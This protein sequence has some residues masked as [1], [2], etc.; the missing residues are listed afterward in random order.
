LTLRRIVYLI[1]VFSLAACSLTLP[2]PYPPN[3]QPAAIQAATTPPGT[4]ITPPAALPTRT[5]DA[6]TPVQNTPAPDARLPVNAIPLTSETEAVEVSPTPE[7]TLPAIGADN[8][9]SLRPATIYPLFRRGLLHRAIWSPDGANLV[10]ETSLGLQVLSAQNLEKRFSLPDTRPLYFIDSGELLVRN[11]RSLSLLDLVEGG[12][13]P[14]EVPLPEESSGE[15]EAYALSPDGKTW[16]LSADGVSL[17]VTDLLNAR[18]ET[19]TLKTQT[20]IPFRVL[21]LSFAP[22]GQRLFA[23]LARTDGETE[24]AVV[25]TAAWQQIYT[26]YNVDSSPLF[27]ADA[28]RMLFESGEIL[29]VAFTGDGMLWNNMALRIEKKI[30]DSQ[31][32]I[33]TAKAYAFFNG[34]REVGVLYNDQLTDR[35][36]PDNRWF[37]STLMIFDTDTTKVTRYVNGLPA[38]ITG[39]SFAPDGERFLTTSEDGVLRVFDTSSEKQLLS[40]E[41]YDVDF[42]PQVRADGR[43]VAYSLLESVSLTDPATGHEL[44]QLGSYPEATHLEA[45]FAGMDTLAIF[46]ETPWRKF[47]DTYDIPSG[48]FLFRYSDLGSCTFNR[49]G[50]IM[51]CF[52][53]VL[54]FFDMPTGRALLDNI[55]QGSGF[56]YSISDSGARVAYCTIGSEFVYLYE[57]RLGS[58]PK[59]IITGKRGVCGKLV[60]SPDES[61]LISSSGFVWSVK[62]GKLLKTFDGLTGGGPAA[63]SPDGSLLLVYPQIANLLNGEVE[64]ELQS[65][66]GVQ[67]AYFLRDGQHLLLQTNRGIELWAVAP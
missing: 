1:V 31:S 6:V 56:E 54:R 27:S 62:N 35:Q 53:G 37:P 64:G 44:A 20:N 42:T 26:L 33:L 58:S 4:G 15:P 23:T 2:N 40:S 13:T 3:L 61:S 60:F 24:M 11:S 30:S 25:D 29:N 51:S 66:P 41:P 45:R 48:S 28:Q 32:D 12:A 38:R 5:P 39:F 49:N 47:L 21:R 63:V 10:L 67:S 9:P 57:V 34:G 43:M 8:A 19:V 52:D 36:L 16:V 65:V 14:L 55:P 22:D 59:L 18:A 17:T 7:A 50:S 46:V